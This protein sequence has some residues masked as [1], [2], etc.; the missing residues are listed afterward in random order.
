MAN[1]IKPVLLDET[2]VEIV[3][4]IKDLKETNGNYVSDIFGYNADGSVGAPLSKWELD[5][6]GDIFCK[7]AYIPFIPQSAKDLKD[8]K[9]LVK[10]S[11][12]SSV[13]TTNSYNS[14]DNRPKLI[15]DKAGKL[16]N[17]EASTKEHNLIG[18][19]N[20]SDLLKLTDFTSLFKGDTV[21]LDENKTIMSLD[22]RVDKLEDSTIVTNTLLDHSVVP[23]MNKHAEEINDLKYKVGNEGD[24]GCLMTRV[25]DLEA[26]DSNVVGRVKDIPIEGKTITEN[27]NYIHNNMQ[28]QINAKAGLVFDNDTDLRVVTFEKDGPDQGNVTG[29]KLLNINTGANCGEG[30]FALGINTKPYRLATD[31]NSFRAALDINENNELE[32]RPERV[33]VADLKDGDEYYTKAEVDALIKAAVEEVLKSVTSKDTDDMEV[34]Q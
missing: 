4:A 32:F 5:S 15:T 2:G 13:A 28:Y 17:D 6:E 33:K 18:N 26:F 25:K 30:L 34:N 1:V 24:A 9:K 22:S 8:Y 23:S 3:K 16:S 21:N 27:L 29:L 11:D 14:L 7:R 12:I 20:V 19:V 10:T 31:E